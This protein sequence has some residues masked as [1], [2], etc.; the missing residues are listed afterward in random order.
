MR[1]KSDQSDVRRDLTE[2][3]RASFLRTTGVKRRRLT[4]TRARQLVQDF[5]QVTIQELAINVERAVDLALEL[6]L[7]AYDGYVLEAARSSGYPLLTLDG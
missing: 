3:Q 1:G 7:Y 4:Q 6:R 5:E 2:M